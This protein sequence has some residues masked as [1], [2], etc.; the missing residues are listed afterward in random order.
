MKQQIAWE[1]LNA[2][3]DGEL[4]PADAAEVAA[5][6]AEDVALARQVADLTSLKAAVSES[7][8]CESPDVDLEAA[9]RNHGGLARVASVAAVFLMGAVLSGL[10]FMG[11]HLSPPDQIVYA[12]AVHGEWL[13]SSREVG[14]RN[15]AR[16]LKVGLQELRLKVRIP[17]LTKVSLTHD[18]IKKISIGKGS[19]LHIGYRGPKGCMLSLVVF[20]N[21]RGL[22][23]ALGEYSRDDRTVYGW[24]TR[25]TGFYLL[26][27]R[28]DPGRLSEIARVVHRMV[29]TRSVLD[30]QSIVALQEAKAAS[31]P[32]TA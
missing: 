6:V 10:L 11:G 27:Y 7:N 3:V 19:G 22:G 31:Q 17:D 29:Q 26:A 30:G 8:H 23:E 16:Q 1:T 9:T 15:Q 28:M 12:E 20:K 13:A 2:Y 21:P 5:A 18:G 14:E 24:R 25:N 4:S 32:C